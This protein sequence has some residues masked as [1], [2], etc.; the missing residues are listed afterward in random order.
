MELFYFIFFYICSRK[1]KKVFP[2]L[3]FTIF[4]IQSTSTLWIFT[5]FYLQ[6]NYIAKN[7][8]INR[9]NQ[10]STCK[11]KCHLKKQ[12]QAKEKQEQKF[13]ELKTQKEFELFFQPYSDIII[14]CK[15]FEIQ[16]KLNIPYCN[17]YTSELV[18]SIF[19]PPKHTCLG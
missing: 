11:G 4:T 8:C 10:K 5:A 17:F 12:F 3:L 6:Q 18:R 9:F 2:I 7:L 1:M 19:H 16:E 14:F 13:P 15:N